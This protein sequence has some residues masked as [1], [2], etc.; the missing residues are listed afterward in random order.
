MF[1][2]LHRRGR[3]IP[4]ATCPVGRDDHLARP[5]A[6]PTCA[7]PR[8]SEHAQGAG[9]RHAGAPS[10]RPC[11]FP[12]A[13]NHPHSPHERPMYVLPVQGACLV[14][15]IL[16]LEGSRSCGNTAAPCAWPQQLLP[17]PLRWHLR[18]ARARAARWLLWGPEPG[19]LFPPGS[20]SWPPLNGSCLGHRSPS[21]LYPV[22][23]Y[24]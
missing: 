8:G 15:T 22:R 6:L 21:S 16:L 3:G 18:P 19:G 12:Q 23:A 24:I 13:V 11:P 9:R 10:S 7:G 17:L 14:P 2:E 1:S 4:L 20:F 5:S